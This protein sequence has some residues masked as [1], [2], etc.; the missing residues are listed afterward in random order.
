MSVIKRSIMCPKCH[1]A[2]T[3]GLSDGSPNREGQRCW[4]C[5]GRYIEVVPKQQAS[6]AVDDFEEFIATVAASVGR[7][8]LEKHDEG[9]LLYA[10]IKDAR[11]KLAALRGR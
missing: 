4:R 2:S 11:A 10:A 5:S 7:L 6:G 9:D 8:R 1:W 3:R